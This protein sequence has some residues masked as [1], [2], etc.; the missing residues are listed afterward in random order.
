MLNK[1]L[2]TERNFSN[3]AS[4][5]DSE[6]LVH[7]KVADYLLAHANLFPSNCYV[8]DIGSGTGIL[9]NKVLHLFNPSQVVNFD[10]SFQMLEQAKLKLPDATYIQGSMENMPLAPGFNVVLSNMSLQWME[11]AS[12]IINTINSCLIPGGIF[13]ISI[14]IEG[15]F[16]TIANLRN[17]IIGSNNE[18]TSSQSE[19]LPSFSSLKDAFNDSQLR[20][21]RSESHLFSHTYKEPI[22]PFN[23]IK[24]LGIAGHSKRILS[25]EE[26]NSLLDRYSEYLEKNNLSPSLDYQVGFFWGT[27]V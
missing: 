14:V 11:S 12:S 18:D 13:A 7:N 8:L 23:A 16:K 20:L 26:F 10:L 24:R 17:E 2:Q 22:E 21:R 6:A 19:R 15:T 4:S 5:Y 25:K 1:T 27:K 9:S 3:A